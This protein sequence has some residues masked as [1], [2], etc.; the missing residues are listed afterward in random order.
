MED[1]IHYP[2]GGQVCENKWAFPTLSQ[3]PIHVAPKPGPARTAPTLLPEIRPCGDLCFATLHDTPDND[4]IECNNLSLRM[5][6]PPPTPLPKCMPTTFA[7]NPSKPGIS[8]HVCSPGPDREPTDAMPL[9]RT[10]VFAHGPN[11]FIHSDSES[12]SDSDLEA[13]AFFEQMML[14]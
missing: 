2:S 13:A 9:V 8:P 14:I 3:T 6:P 4:E 7:H 11:E 1:I 12:D 10:T 5:G